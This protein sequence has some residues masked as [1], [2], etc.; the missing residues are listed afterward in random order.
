M[1]ADG[2]QAHVTL[3]PRPRRTRLTAWDALDGKVEPERETEQHV[4]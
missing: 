2:T 4:S 3:G 1:S